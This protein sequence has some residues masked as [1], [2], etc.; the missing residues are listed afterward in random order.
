MWTWYTG[1]TCSHGAEWPA[2]A[3]QPME[4]LSMVMPTS[5]AAAWNVHPGGCPGGMPG[6]CAIPKF[7]GAPHICQKPSKDSWSLL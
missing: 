7:H 5:E 6:R 2:P 4:F 1:Y 3:A